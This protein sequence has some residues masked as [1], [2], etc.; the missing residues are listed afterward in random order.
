MFKFLVF[1]GT[2]EGRKIIEYLLRCNAC[3]HACVATEY[4]KELLDTQEN[5]IIYAKRMDFDQMVQL[6]QSQRFDLV[7]DATHPYA[8]EV[9]E[10]SK[11]ACEKCKVRY[12]RVSRP[13]KKI[14]GCIFVETI[15]KAAEYL[16]DTQGPILLTTGS[17]QLKAFTVI[18][19][20][21]TRIYPRILPVPENIQYALELGYQGKN[22]ICMQGPFSQEMNLAMLRQIHAAY[23]V[24][25]ESGDAGGFLEKITAAKT[26]GAVPIVV[27]RPAPQE[28]YT[29]EEIL[30]L[31]RADFA[32]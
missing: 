19:D 32:L 30:E 18:K 14:E 24:T 29:Y 8:K 22:L 9:T 11:A 20:F 7:I 21:S 28:G 26:A 6:I 13:V 27:G 31:L 2:S 1:A 12:L 17:K 16:S 10:N 5:L 23:L 25:K 4:G 3:V 15:Q